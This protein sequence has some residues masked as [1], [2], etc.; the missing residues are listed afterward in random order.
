MENFPLKEI[1]PN[2]IDYKY[3]IGYLQKSL[4]HSYL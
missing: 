3:R 2:Q 1:V 4:F